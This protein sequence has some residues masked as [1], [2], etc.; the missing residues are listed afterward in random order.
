MLKIAEWNPD[1]PLFDPMCGSGT[2]LLKRNDSTEDAACM[3]P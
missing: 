1:I 3:A 2:I